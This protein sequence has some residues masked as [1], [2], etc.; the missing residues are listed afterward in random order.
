MAIR[1]KPLSPLIGAE[2]DGVDLGKP[3]D[4]ATVDEIRRA[5][6]EHLVVI[7]RDQNL[8]EADQIRFTRYLGAPQYYPTDRASPLAEHKDLVLVIGNIRVDGKVAGSLS[9]GELTQHADSLWFDMPPKGTSLF[10]I[11]VPKKGG[12]TFFASMP[13]AY[14]LL[15]K[16]IAA[17]LCGA[18]AQFRYNKGAK[19]RG[20]PAGDSVIE[21]NVH[22]AVILH[23]VSG[24]KMI[25]VN[26]L[27]TTS[28]EGMSEAESEALLQAAYAACADPT[29]RF[30]HDWRPGDFLLWDN[31]ATQHGRVDF[32]PTE[33]RFLKRV[34]LRGETRPMAARAD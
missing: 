1:V 10:A 21:S 20:D 4:A 14:D 30:Y 23:P 32:D 16:D 22:P 31:W 26:Q 34:T 28:L 15:P 13:A 25:F 27:M 9:D 2:I 17:R 24:R 5:W 8:T 19:Y 29:I 11:E 7:F 33:R 3:L 6:V 12:Q 18:R